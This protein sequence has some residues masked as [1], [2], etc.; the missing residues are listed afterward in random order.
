[1]AL[2]L[3]RYF[4]VRQGGFFLQ[5]KTTLKSTSSFINREERF[6]RKRIKPQIVGSSIQHP[7]TSADE[8]RRRILGRV[9]NYAHNSTQLFAHLSRKVVIRRRSIFQNGERP[10]ARMRA[11]PKL[12]W[13]SYQRLRCLRSPLRCHVPVDFSLIRAIKS[14]VK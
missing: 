5:E 7:K 6:G 4:G 10:P 1:M 9:N 14:E 3:V 2:Q 8:N 11:T 13:H 12:N